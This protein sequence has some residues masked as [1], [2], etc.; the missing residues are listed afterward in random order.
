MQTQLQP[1]NL[2]Q[3]E[4]SNPFEDLLNRDH[5]SQAIALPSGCPPARRFVKVSEI[6]AEVEVERQ[7]GFSYS[8]CAQCGERSCSCVPRVVVDYAET[9]SYPVEMVVATV[10]S[11]Q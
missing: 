7:I 10:I 3:S 11:L 4:T 6:T 9:I 5:V 8:V 1:A 2:A